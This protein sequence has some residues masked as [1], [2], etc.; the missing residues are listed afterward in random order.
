MWMGTGGV[1]GG[2]KG[3]RITGQG[4]AQGQGDSRV[5]A[6]IASPSSP[7][8]PWTGSIPLEN[9]SDPSLPSLLLLT[10][11]PF[12]SQYLDSY[13][14]SPHPYLLSENSFNHLSPR[15]L[16]FPLCHLRR[17]GPHLDTEPI[18]RHCAEPLRRLQAGREKGNTRKLGPHILFEQHFIKPCTLF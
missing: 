11:P 18:H 15:F 10:P 9:L 4:L 13:F 12:F 5:S 16:S 14:L 6:R 1:R 8:W 2:K 17:S 3:Q 7:T